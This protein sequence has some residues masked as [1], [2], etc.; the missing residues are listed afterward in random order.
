MFVLL[1]PLSVMVSGYFVVVV[2][3]LDTLFLA[4]KRARIPEVIEDGD[5]NTK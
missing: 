4:E 3:A 1:L 2:L 5:G